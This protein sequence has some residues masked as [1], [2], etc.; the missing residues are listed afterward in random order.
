MR[1]HSN[2]VAWTLRNLQ[3]KLISVMSTRSLVRE[4]AVDSERV[5]L[6]KASICTREGKTVT[7][8]CMTTI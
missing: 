1:N 6:S 3:K 8:I 5:R 4:V 2:L 7:R